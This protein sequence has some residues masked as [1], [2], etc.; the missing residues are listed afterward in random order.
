MIA[1]VPFAVI[2]TRHA[3]TRARVSGLARAAF[4]IALLEALAL[5]VLMVAGLLAELG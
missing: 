2:T 5:V 4:V 3:A 1:G